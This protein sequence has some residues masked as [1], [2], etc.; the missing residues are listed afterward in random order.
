MGDLVKDFLIEAAESIGQADV[1]LERVP[2]IAPA[3]IAGFDGRPAGPPPPPQEADEAV[4]PSLSEALRVQMDAVLHD[5]AELLD[6]TRKMMAAWTKRRHEAMEAGLQA[7]Q[8]FSNAED[9]GEIAAAY[10]EWLTSS[11]SRIMTD[12]AVAR[13]GTLRLA[14]LGTKRK[15]GSRATAIKV[16]VLGRGTHSG[17]PN[18]KPLS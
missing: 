1:R 18:T 6:E 9:I 2:S 11:M 7:L 12:M 5:Q 13:D 8:T 3:A 16:P 14:G 17:N 10:D 15:S 4:I